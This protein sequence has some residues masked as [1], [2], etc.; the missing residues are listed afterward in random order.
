MAAQPPPRVLEP[1]TSKVADL[2]SRLKD[3]AA[4]PSF[5]SGVLRAALKEQKRIIG[6]PDAP[7]P[8]FLFSEN[9]NPGDTVCMEEVVVVREPNLQHRSIALQTRASFALNLALTLSLTFLLALAAARTLA[10]TPTYPTSPGAP[11]SPR[12]GSRA[13]SAA[14]ACAAPSAPP[15]SHSSQ[16]RRPS[17][18][19][20]RSPT[21][22]APT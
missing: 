11:P 17:R 2:F 9:L 19:R 13:A 16:S 18:G 14:T 8:R 4:S 6:A 12:K 15:F 1:A 7:D 3:G 5:H 20:R 22:R 10:L 21:S